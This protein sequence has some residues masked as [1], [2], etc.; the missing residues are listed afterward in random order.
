MG[1]LFLF[2]K[3]EYAAWT[4]GKLKPDWTGLDTSA[5]MSMCSP[6]QIDPMYATL[7]VK[8]YNLQIKDWR[9]S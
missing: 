5:P 6:E 4:G 7:Q 8:G 2:S 9:P 3:D 1:G